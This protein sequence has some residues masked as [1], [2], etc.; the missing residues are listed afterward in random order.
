MIQDLSVVGMDIAKRVFHLVG[1]D[2]RGKIT[3]RTRF[4][5]GEVLTFMATLPP[6]TVG[7]EACGGA[8]YWARRLREHGHMVKLMAPPY[9][10]PYVKTNKNDMR[11]AEAIAEAVTRPS[12]RCVPIKTVAQQDIQALHRVRERL[13][14]ARTAL[15]N[16]MRGLFAEYGIVLPVGIKACRQGVVE[17]LA[18]E[19]AKLTPL[20]EELFRTLWKALEK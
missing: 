10:K 11:D 14:G 13:I 20:S 8:H 16:A 1:M 7:M 9:V 3:L 5:R 15:M 4:M 18:A 12:M 2:E 19:Q 17:T 6:V